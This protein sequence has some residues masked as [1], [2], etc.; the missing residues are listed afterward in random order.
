VRSLPWVIGDAASSVGAA[1]G[2]A[3]PVA[4]L[5]APKPPDRGDTPTEEG[6]REVSPFAR[7]PWFALNAFSTCA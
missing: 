6:V 7:E 1:I 2:G 3:A 5:E 4:A